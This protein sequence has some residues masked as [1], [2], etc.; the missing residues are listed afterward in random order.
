ME[1]SQLLIKYS[2]I[3]AD[4][5]KGR[6]MKESGMMR[7]KSA[8]NDLEELLVGRVR[9]LC[10]LM[11]SEQRCSEQESLLSRLLE[12]RMRKLTDTMKTR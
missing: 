6:V 8:N 11:V 2:S 5:L 10:Q 12:D 3:A 1:I 4:K 7:C 9:R